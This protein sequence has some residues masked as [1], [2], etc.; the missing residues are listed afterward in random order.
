MEL[1]KV[2]AYPKF[3]L[4][5]HE[6]HELIDDFLPFCDSVSMLSSL[7]AVLE[8]RDIHDMPF[9]QLALVGQAKFLVTGDHDLLML[10]EYFPVTI[11]APAEFIETINI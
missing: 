2:L 7:P 8:C 5:E 9:L 11:L 10:S 4:N 1:I 6:Q 3:S